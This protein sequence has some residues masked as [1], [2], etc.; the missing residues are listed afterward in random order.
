M[1]IKRL[2]SI[3][4][5]VRFTIDLSKPINSRVNEILIL[6][7]PP[8]PFPSSILEEEKD[9]QVVTIDFLINGGDGYDYLKN[10]HRNFRQGKC[11]A[12]NLC[13]IL[14][15]LLSINTAY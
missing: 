7:R 12:N 3:I 9:Y 2:L 13:Y 8:S 6:Q 10:N 1:I 11:I 5:G 15:D 4:T 14:L